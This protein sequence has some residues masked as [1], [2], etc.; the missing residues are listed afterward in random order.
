MSSRSSARRQAKP[1]VNEDSFLDLLLAAAR[2]LLSDTKNLVIGFLGML[3]IVF[4]LRSGGA[5]TGMVA[6]NGVASAAQPIYETAF[7]RQEAAMQRLQMEDVAKMRM[8]ADAMVQRPAASY[9]APQAAVVEDV[10]RVQH[11]VHD[12]QVPVYAHPVAPVA[13]V[14]QAPPPPVVQD[15]QVPVYAQQAP[16][17]PVVP[18]QQAPVAPVFAQQA[19]PAPVVPVHQAPPPP[20]VQAEFTIPTPPASIRQGAVAV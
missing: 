1:H 7:Q 13:Q 2:V 3:V 14:Q 9:Q 11:A 12:S 4:A 19:P 10:Q 18:V 6:M 8:Q 20:V 16:L 5:A 15:S 17:A